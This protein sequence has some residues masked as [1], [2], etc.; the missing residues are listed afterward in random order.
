MSSS[1]NPSRAGSVAPPAADRRPVIVGVS[2]L[3][4]HTAYD[5]PAADPLAML[6]RVAEEA[7][8]DAGGRRVLDAVDVVV[9]LPF[10]WWSERDPAARVARE[11]GIEPRE[12]WM[13][14][15]GG[16]V[17]P[18]VLNWAADR[19]AA[20]EAR[21]VL[22][23]GGNA[24]RTLDVVSKR[25]EQA[26]WAAAGRVETAA[27][28]F[29]TDRMGHS[30]E[31]VAVGLDLPIRLYPVIENAIRAAKGR[32]I[33]E[34]QRVIGEMFSRFTDVAAANPHAW[35]P[36]AR[37]AEE[38]T[39][40]TPENRW[41]SFPYPKYVNAVIATD[42]AAAFIITTSGV[43]DELGVAADRRVFWWGGH[44]QAER[45]WYVSTRPTIATSPA[46]T[47]SHLTALANARCTVD[48]VGHI[49]LYSCFPAPVELAC[50]VLG[51]SPLDS[52]GLTV[53]GGLPYAGGPGS[54]YP[55]HSL[56]AMT[57]RLRA[58]PDSVGLVTGNGWYASKHSAVVLSG[59]PRPDG[60]PLPGPGVVHPD[61][62]PIANRP[63][64]GTVVSYTVHFGNDGEPTGG[65]VVADM[66]DGTRSLA[67]LDGD[68]D[69]FRRFVADERVGSSG[70][71]VDRDGQ[72]RF[73]PS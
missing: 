58:G 72:L 18:V 9:A 64:D 31:E 69:D 16:E 43:A 1:S 2:Q 47:E 4:T 44:A 61:P 37:S 30:D 28:K 63:G 19:L 36:V 60:E 8:A 14:N 48:D 68:A 65:S 55:L 12:T 45:A 10:L 53:T 7:G 3:S 66:G 67:R 70:T 35:F 62:V 40:I 73:D 13:T 56:A 51:I 46:M 22:V 27:R 20:G 11:I 52:R 59:R 25:G 50:D 32:S 34:H 57:D 54:A 21:A 26:D 41:I 33:D 42:Q 15:D 29:G 39:T 38:L 71:V 23:L 6:T 24:M 49:D 17:A 5:G